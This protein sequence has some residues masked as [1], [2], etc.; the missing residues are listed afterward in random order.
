M[1]D[2]PQRPQPPEGF[3]RPGVPGAGNLLD[4][5]VRGELREKIHEGGQGAR[6]QV[7]EA[8]TAPA[9]D[10]GSQT[11][12]GNQRQTAPAAD[13]PKTP[14][15]NRAGPFPHGDVDLSGLAANVTPAKPR[16]SRGQR[17][18]Y[19]LKETMSAPDDDTPEP[20]AG[21]KPG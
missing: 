13:T 5:A 1:A 11:E 10:A 20:P 21:P 14:P 16:R 2:A 15:A 12:F 19:F 6:D 8:Q 4:P 9:A 18:F 17:R 3:Q 7:K